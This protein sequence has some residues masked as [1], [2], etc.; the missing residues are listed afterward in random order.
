M[1]DHGGVNK[2]RLP[3]LLSIALIG[4][5]SVTAHSLGYLAFARAGERGGEVAEGSH[6]LESHL[7]LLLAM[8]GAAVAVGV[9]SRIVSAAR[10]RP[11]GDASVR[12]FVLL[13]PLGFAL[14]EAIERVLHVESFPWNGMHEPA[15][16]AALL[17]QIPFGIVAFVA[18][19]WLTRVAV[20]IGRLLA[21]G[22]LRPRRIAAAL[23]RPADVL[24]PR[25][26]RVGGH[27][28]LQRAPPRRGLVH[29]P[30]VVAAN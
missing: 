1:C 19:L 30:L 22:E 8:L 15:F 17:L 6:G 18:A 28:S 14:Q 5:G 20:G 16:L 21:G 10:G 26:Y 4:L 27:D 3:W 12:W 23:I 13:P 24:H 2:R 9:L 7:P 25:R 11:A 29:L